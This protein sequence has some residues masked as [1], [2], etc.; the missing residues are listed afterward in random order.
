MSD[1]CGPLQGVLRYRVYITGERYAL[2]Q[3]VGYDI[4]F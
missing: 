4:I 3:R 1:R 2:A